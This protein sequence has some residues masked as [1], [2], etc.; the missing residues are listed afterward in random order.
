M[1]TPDNFDVDRPI[2]FFIQERK[3]KDI[4]MAF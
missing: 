2:N 1:K 4:T 3:I